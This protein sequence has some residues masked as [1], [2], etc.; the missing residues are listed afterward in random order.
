MRLVLTIF[1]LWIC[2]L[3]TAQSGLGLEVELDLASVYTQGQQADVK[4]DIFLNDTA[5]LEQAVLFLNIVERD[6]A[7][8]YPQ[9]AHKIFATAKEVPSV[10]RKVY[11]GAALSKGVETTLSF[12]LRD[13]AKVGDYS[14]VVQLFEGDETN[15]NRVK[16]ENR[17]ALKGFDFSITE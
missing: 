1:C 4:F 12:Q 14:L 9:A 7:G 10:F 8:K 16:V 3:G 6:P 15:P 2:G 17:L 13:G 5:D 11:T